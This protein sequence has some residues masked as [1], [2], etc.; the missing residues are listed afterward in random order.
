[1][2]RVWCFML[3]SRACPARAEAALLLL[4]LLLP[5]LLPAPP[6]S[7]SPLPLRRRRSYRRTCRP[8]LPATSVFSPSSAM[9]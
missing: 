8:A 7:C 9:A 1:M 3:P 2:A 6:S 5:P 4:L